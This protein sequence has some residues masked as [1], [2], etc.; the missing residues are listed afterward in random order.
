MCPRWWR[1]VPITTE[2]ADAMSIKGGVI[3]EVL[4]EIS[5][6]HVVWTLVCVRADSFYLCVCASEEAAAGFRERA[7][8]QARRSFSV[9]HFNYRADRRSCDSRWRSLVARR[10]RDPLRRLVRLLRFLPQHLA[11]RLPSHVNL[12]GGS[13]G[14]R[15]E[16]TS[17]KRK[18][19][20]LYSGRGLLYDVKM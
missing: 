18:M 11:L 2:G 7:R 19:A 1:A 14:S 13:R 15:S 4:S 20:P 3:T 12:A 10:G 5:H 9:I 17:A 16:E 6:K 8:K